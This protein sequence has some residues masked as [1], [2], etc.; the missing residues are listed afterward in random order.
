M[1]V[2]NEGL[3]PA[4]LDNVVFLTTVPYPYKIRSCT[5]NQDENS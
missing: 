4:K 2:K 5:Q 3:V 1:A